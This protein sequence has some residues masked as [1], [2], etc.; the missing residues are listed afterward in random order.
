MQEIFTK[1]YILFV[2]NTIQLHNKEYQ[3]SLWAE[4]WW[5]KID[6]ISM[7]KLCYTARRRNQQEVVANVIRKYISTPTDVAVI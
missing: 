1:L 6:Q 2:V 7:D 4:C 5:A 3:I